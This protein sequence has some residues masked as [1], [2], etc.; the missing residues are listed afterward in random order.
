MGKFMVK[1]ETISVKELHNKLKTKKVGKLAEEVFG[2]DF[3]IYCPSGGMTIN[4]KDSD[5]FLTVITDINRF[6]LNRKEYFNKTYEL[7][8]KYEQNFGCEV[9]IKTEYSKKQT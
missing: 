5:V 9:T 7:A 8:E 6:S 1:I 2:K 3:K 4:E